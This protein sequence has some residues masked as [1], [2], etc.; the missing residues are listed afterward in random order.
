M[1]Q[2]PEQLQ[3]KEADSRTDI[4]AAGA[5]LYEMLTGQ[6]AFG[7]NSPAAVIGNILHVEPSPLSSAEPAASPALA[8]LVSKCLA[9]DPDARRQSASD[10]SDEL[11]WIA[12]GE[13]SRAVESDGLS[14]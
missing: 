1:T 10:V 2:P 14:S 4:F 5:V 3:G 13:G 8:R 12:G 6:K 11:R 7:G 9:K